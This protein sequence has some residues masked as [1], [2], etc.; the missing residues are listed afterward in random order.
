MSLHMHRTCDFLGYPS[1]FN[2]AAT[3][4]LHQ[5]EALGRVASFTMTIYWQRIL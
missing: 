4:Q 2:N 3:A 5:A 1:H